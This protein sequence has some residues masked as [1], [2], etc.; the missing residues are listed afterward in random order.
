M[1]AFGMTGRE[2]EALTFIKSY[3]RSHG[4]SMPSL[5]EIAGGLGLKA[6]SGAHR[7]VLSL[8]DRGHLVRLKNRH[9]SI[10]LLD[11]QA[12]SDLSVPVLSR[13]LGYAVIAGIGPGEALNLAVTE[14][15]DALEKAFLTTKNT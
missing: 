11:P 7:I 13:L 14:G 10:K 1:T 9:R 15:L 2:R 8:E 5:S 12:L 3:A 4:G 6:R